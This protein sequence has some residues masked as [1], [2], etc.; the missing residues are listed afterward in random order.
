VSQV[1][2][3]LVRHL[4]RVAV[5][6]GLAPLADGELL[7]RYAADRD[8]AAFEA[9]V[10]RHGAMVL[11]A[12]ARVLGRGGDAE[13]A[14]QAT[15]LA[16]VRHARAVR[17]DGSLAG[18]LYRVARRVST[19]ASRE[20]V[21]RARRECRAARAE[22]VTSD[23]A[24]WADWRA[25]LDREVERL[26]RHYR[27]AFV[28]CHL[29]GRAHEDAAREL[30]CPLGTLH[31]RLARAKERLRARLGSLPVVA[32]VV[33]SERL[34]GAT[35]R[36]AAGLA[37]GSAVTTAVA[38]SQG[39]WSPMALF[40]AKLAVAAVSVVVTVGSGA[41]LL[42]PPAA[43]ATATQT[44][45]RPAEPTIDEL[46]RENE[47]LRREVAHLKKLLSV[48]EKAV[49]LRPD[50]DP[51]TDAEI[52]RVMPKAAGAP[53]G[54]RDNIVIVKEKL[55]DRLDPPRELPLVGPAR[56][57]HRHWQCT[58]YYTETEE[59]PGQGR[60]VTPRVQV[61]YLDQDMLVRAAEG[62]K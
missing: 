35:A 3:E 42:G 23:A 18:W 4:G 11:G 5:R 34:V 12:C 59:R 57:R 19:R 1:L 22:A 14:F 55:I 53:P 51:P 2:S 50:D 32:G 39:V 38:L 20:R 26:P 8:P 45:A 10:R 48:Q 28:L 62:T 58:V 43:T 49:A 17:A 37:D 15:F 52:L 40:N 16:L 60:V 36:A 33:V 24:E 56:L 29:D 31:S 13:D 41:L 44:P 27:E 21:L 54:F 46:R 7:R 30:G 61:V 9:L 47:R 25:A 6:D